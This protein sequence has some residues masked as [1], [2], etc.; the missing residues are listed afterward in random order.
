M[1]TKQTPIPNYLG[2]AIAA[3]ILF[4]PLGIPA[5]IKS[6]RVNTLQNQGKI[7]EAIATSK[8][9]HKFGKLGIIIGAIVI[10]LYIIEVIV[11]IAANC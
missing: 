9:A 11:I 7:D 1:D 4:F 10:A 2:L 8:S 5:L 3:L 6:I